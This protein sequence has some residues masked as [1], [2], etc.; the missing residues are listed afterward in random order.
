[1]RYTLA[2]APYPKKSKYLNYGRKPSK[3]SLLIS[4]FVITI[5]FSIKKEFHFI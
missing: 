2:N 5:I 4:K 3:N 1:M